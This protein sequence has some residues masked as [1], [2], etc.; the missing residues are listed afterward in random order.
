MGCRQSSSSATYQ[1]GIKGDNDE[2]RE[3]A[4]QAI[5]DETAQ[6]PDLV[7]RIEL[8]LACSNLRRHSN[9]RV[10]VYLKAGVEKYQLVGKTEILPDTENPTFAQG[11]F[12]DFFFEVQQ[13][14]RFEVYHVPGNNGKV[15]ESDFLGLSEMF[16]AEIVTSAGGLVTREMEHPTRP[17]GNG[18][19]TIIAEE[20]QG[21]KRSVK[22]NMRGSSLPKG[23]L[24]SK[25]QYYV[26]ISRTMPA[27]EACAGTPLPVVYRSEVANDNIEPSFSVTDLSVESLCRGEAT[28]KILFQL[29]DKK[30]PDKLIGTGACCLED[31]ESASLR[32]VPVTVDLLSPGPGGSIKTGALVLD[33]VE[34]VKHVSFLEYVEGGLEINLIVAIDFT[35]SNGDPNLP[36]SLHYY[37]PGRAN[38]YVMAIRAVGEIL[39]HYDQ[40][41]RLVQSLLLDHPSSDKKY[42]VYGFGAKLPP[43]Y[44]HTSHLFACNGNYFLPEVAGVDGIVDAYRKALQVVHLHGP[45]MFSDIIHLASKWAE[46]YNVKKTNEQK[47][48]ILLILTDGAIVDLQATIDAIVEASKTPLSI[49]IVGVGDQDFGMMDELDADD[50]PLVSSFDHSIM[51]RD[52]VQFV[53]FNEFKDKSYTELAMATLD[54]VPREVVN[55]YYKKNGVP[56]LPRRDAAEAAASD[57]PT[58]DTQN[59]VAPQCIEQERRRTLRI[60]GKSGL[61]TAE[62]AELVEDSLP[63]IEDEYTSAMAK[64]HLTN[65]DD[66]PLDTSG[67]PFEECLQQLKQHNLLFA[68]GVNMSLAS[69]RL[70]PMVAQSPNAQSRGGSRRASSSSRGSLVRASTV[71]LGR[72]MISVRDGAGG[73]WG[74]ND[75]MSPL[76]AESPM[77]ADSSPLSPVLESSTKNETN[78]TQGHRRASSQRRSRSHGHL[79]RSGSLFGSNLDED[80]GLCKVCFENATNTVLLP[81]KHQC[82]CLDCAAG[83][84]DSSGKCPICRLRIE[85]II[86]AIQS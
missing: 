12:V 77:P 15:R 26:V 20:V 35:F 3:A 68:H 37:D 30:G 27:A 8:K 2:V 59:F 10:K 16:L 21:L 19:I 74:E 66:A 50:R 34:L 18:K 63:C 85:T 76:T 83:V 47:Y 69:S 42:P 49:I 54:E 40:G 62:A 38:D 14:V 11:V 44:T 1:T 7:T 48:F 56:P 58:D 79:S 5:G 31:F 65:R 57:P 86:D 36:T 4:R 82:M 53:P 39:E 75:I 80:S 67:G 9:C 23:G 28:R 17:T 32:Q 29:L 6:A 64:R 52:I 51:E 84:K 43:D 41:K 24:L 60:L 55:Y 33:N 72:E 22:F 78:D 25:P 70:S 46:Q 81:C 45:T 13:R 61:S 71:G 73:S